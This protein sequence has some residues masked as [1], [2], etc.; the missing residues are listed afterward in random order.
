MVC[1]DSALP[2]TNTRKS[3]EHTS[4]ATAL[5]A[6]GT[7]AAP[8]WPHGPRPCH[9]LV[10]T[11]PL[12]NK[13]VPVSGPWRPLLPRPGA[14]FPASVRPALI[15]DTRAAGGPCLSRAHWD[16][17]SIPFPAV[18]TPS[19]GLGLMST[20]S[21]LPLLR[22]DR[23]LSRPRPF[24]GAWGRC[25]TAGRPPVSWEH[26]AGPGS[27]PR[28]EGLQGRQRRPPQAGSCRSQSRWG[29][30]SSVH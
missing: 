10:L 21:F 7:S 27:V 19:A 22:G 28:G 5:P 25:P 12:L 3:R 24:P 14:L 15:L 17:T 11:A 29:H 4:A 30:G 18:A 9:A 6:P 13:R 16:A 2:T 8:A 20:P 23:A 26:D 1:P